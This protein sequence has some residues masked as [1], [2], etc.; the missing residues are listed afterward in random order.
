MDGRTIPIAPSHNPLNADGGYNLEIATHAGRRHQGA[1]MKLHR[2]ALRLLAGGIG[3]LALA[4]CAGVA[5]AQPDASPPVP[6]IIDQLVTSTPALSVDPSDEGG[7]ST[8][9]GGVGMVCQNLRVRC[10]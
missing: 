8:Q 5:H 3:V 4:W 9:W 6:S 1:T 2:C 10:R 7:R